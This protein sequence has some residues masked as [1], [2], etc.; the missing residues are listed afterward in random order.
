V[1]GMRN[2]PASKETQTVKNTVHISNPMKPKRE[3][4]RDGK[5]R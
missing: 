1:N 2:A 5:D 3:R 4:E